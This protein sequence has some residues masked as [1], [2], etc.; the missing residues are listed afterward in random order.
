MYIGLQAVIGLCSVR[1]RVILQ[2]EQQCLA[3]DAE[4][5]EICVQLYSSAFV[6]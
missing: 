1:V 3:D 4:V 2:I 6:S 5:T